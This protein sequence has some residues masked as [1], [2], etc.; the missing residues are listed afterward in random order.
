MSVLAYVSVRKRKCVREREK[1]KYVV[2]VYE[3]VCM[4]EQKCMRKRKRK[5]KW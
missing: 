4:P 3:C 2:C 5:N 1:D